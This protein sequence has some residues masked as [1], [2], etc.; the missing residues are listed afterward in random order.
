MKALLEAGKQFDVIYDT[1]SSFDPSDPNYE[2][3]LRPLLKDGG[4]YVAIN[5]MRA[6]WLRGAI[7]SYCQYHLFHVL[8]LFLRI[9]L[10]RDISV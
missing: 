2:P 10:S 6:D 9:S 8:I 4:R 7:V 1:V 3:E 5:G